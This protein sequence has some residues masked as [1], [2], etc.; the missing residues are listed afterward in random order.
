MYGSSVLLIQRQ[1][2]SKMY[3]FLQG[4]YSLEVGKIVKPKIEKYSKMS[5]EL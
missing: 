5:K 1:E 2:Y 4:V 3:S